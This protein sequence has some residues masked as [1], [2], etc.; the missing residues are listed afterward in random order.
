MDG[1]H[2]REAARR[3][4]DAVAPGYEQAYGS[5]HH[6]L[7]AWYRRENLHLLERV[8]PPGAHLLEL[9]CGAG[10]EAC[11]LAERGR[12]VTSVDVSPAM[13][14][15]LRARAARLGVGAQVR[16]LVA[17][18]GELASTAELADQRFDGAFSSFGAL[19]TEPDLPAVARA[20]A[21]LLGAGAPAA[22][23]VVN[24]WCAWEIGWGLL[25]GQARFAT[26]RLEPG[27]QTTR[28]GPSA[29]GQ[30][31]VVSMRACS[32]SELSSAFA[33]WFATERVEG[34]GVA[35]PPTY[36]EVAFARWAR[37]TPA[38]EALERRLAPRW[39]FRSLGDHVR[40]VLRRRP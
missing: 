11:W 28:I 34:V 32:A 20:L 17:A 4:Y 25:H 8:F 5:D 19:N 21:G 24:R 37:L 26:R 13:I 36:L 35:L 18:A 9:G 39:P 12:V 6:R 22:I 16:G 29:S 15:L 1:A 3:A 7:M 40:L 14:E 10:E 31:A 27:W 33:P 30:Q 38:L 23:S 2:V